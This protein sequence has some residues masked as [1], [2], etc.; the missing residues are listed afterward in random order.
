M[1]EG[2]FGKLK[3]VVVREAR[4]QIIWVLLVELLLVPQ[5]IQCVLNACKCAPNEIF[6]QCSA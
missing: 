2:A 4:W 6:R 1:R 5:L 3:I